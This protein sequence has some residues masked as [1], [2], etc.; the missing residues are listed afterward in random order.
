MLQLVLGSLHHFSKSS[1]SGT[2]S[3]TWRF[4][5]NFKT[6]QKILYF[7]FGNLRKILQT[8]ETF[9]HFIFYNRFITLRQISFMM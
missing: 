8:S 5:G 3:K 6:I 4:S 9:W 2:L 1:F 7:L